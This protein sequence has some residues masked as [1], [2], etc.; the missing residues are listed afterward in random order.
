MALDTQMNLHKY[1]NFADK[2]LKRSESHV[3]LG[4]LKVSGALSDAVKDIREADDL[5]I[6]IFIVERGVK[7]HKSKSTKSTHVQHL[8]VMFGQ[9]NI[10]LRV[11]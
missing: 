5:R 11:V 2:L 10:L 8:W 6:K 7:H 1:D 3:E 9:T 4:L